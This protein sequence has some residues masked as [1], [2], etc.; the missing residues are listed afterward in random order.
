M[1]RFKRVQRTKNGE[2]NIRFV[3][4]AIPIEADL[5]RVRQLRLRE[6]LLADPTFGGKIVEPVWTGDIDNDSIDRSTLKP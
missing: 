3:Q 1:E 6:A 4:M 2:P 5:E